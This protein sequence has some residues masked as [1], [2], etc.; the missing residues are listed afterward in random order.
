MTLLER[1]EGGREGRAMSSELPPLIPRT[2]IF[3]NPEKADPQVSPDGKQLA[4]LAPLDGVLNVW[5][6]PLGGDEFRPVTH[7]VDRGVRVYFWA[8]DAEH[9]LFL[10]DAGGDENWRLYKVRL[11]T[12]ATEDLTPFDDVQV[13]IAGR[14]KRHPNELLIGMNKEDVRL[15][16]VYH[17]DLTTNELTLVAKNPG[18]VLGWVA[19][20]D[21]AVRGALAS[22]PDGGT[23]LRIRDSID[24]EW[25][26]LLAWSPEDAM[27]SAPL[28]F[29]L[30]GASLYLADSRRANAARLMTVHLGTGRTEVIAEDSQYD[31]S[32]VIVHPDTREIQMVAFT[33]ARQEW[34]VLDPAIVRDV[35]AI[36]ELDPG[37]FDL[38]SRSNDDAV[39]IIEFTEDDGPVSYYAFDR[40]RRT[41]S[42]LF[43]TRPDLA[44]YDLASMEPIVFDSRDRLTI[45][46]YLTTPPG[47]R[48]EPLPM[49][50]NVHGGPWHRD[51]WGYDPE[52]QW[53]ANR[54]Y[55]CLQVNFRGSTGY[56]KAFLNAGNREWGGKMHD[57]LVDAVRWAVDAGVAD[58]ERIAIYGGSYGGYAALAGATFTPEIFTCAVDIVGPSNLITFIET[59]PPYWSS[60]LAMLH[61]RVGNPEID[62]DFLK[63]R[64]PLSHVDRIQ[65]PMLIAQ[66]ANDPRVKQAESEQIVAVM[67]EKGI[68]HDYMLFPDE[69]HGFAK[70]ENRLEFYAAA[71][72]FLA[73]HLGG[74]F[75]PGD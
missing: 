5:V 8:H 26:T 46:G 70:P 7:D 12:D 9:I 50:L 13:Q 18:N 61:E 71:E 6:G 41:A 25:R 38:H 34:D 24:A 17:L 54:G 28:G 33:R 56:G 62:A 74:R 64:S 68:D 48:G 66:G 52:A 69:G 60:Y 16:D 19:D 21:F 51:V 2:V 35:A 75:E 57:D 72:R 23:E 59:I 29:T 37:D 47:V 45:H 1:D 42:F 11:D 10:Q 43:H 67:R 20:P 31:V 22:T 40:T 14:D 49:V 53:F 65:I 44:R 63:S 39:W 30:D 4:Y 58:P 36:R 15:H 73:K 32:G 55:A 27:S 3:G